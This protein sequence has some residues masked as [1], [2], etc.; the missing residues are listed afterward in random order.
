MIVEHTL[1]NFKIF[2]DLTTKKKNA[3]MFCISSNNQL[4][5]QLLSPYPTLERKD[6]P[7]VYKIHELFLSL[8]I[9]FD[10]KLHFI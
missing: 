7:N 9:T 8:S 4:F 2:Y 5:S 1:I 3:P 6:T 10:I